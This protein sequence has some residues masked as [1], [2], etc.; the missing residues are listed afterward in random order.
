MQN[1]KLNRPIGVCLPVS[2]HGGFHIIHTQGYTLSPRLG[3]EIKTPSQAQSLLRNNNHKD[4]GGK[5]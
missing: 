4:V 1:D 5:S 3:A 2:E